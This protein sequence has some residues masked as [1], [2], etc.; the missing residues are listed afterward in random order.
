MAS[1]KLIELLNELNSTLLVA[2]QKVHLFHY[3]VKGVNF[4]TLH[5]VL[6]GYY[7]KIFDHVDEVAEEILKL[8]GKPVAT[9]ANAL[10]LS[11]IK[12]GKDQTF[13]EEEPLKKELI[14]DFQKIQAL[15]Q[16]IHALADEEE[17]F[18][19]SDLLDGIEDFYSKAIWMLRQDLA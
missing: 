15:I 16:K 13:L 11:A 5:Q 19:T 9:Y 18:T 3:Y 17:V 4:F 14:S 6:E 7:E 10:K 8:S 12:E 2:T 1:K